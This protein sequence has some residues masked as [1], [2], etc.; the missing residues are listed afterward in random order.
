VVGRYAAEIP[1][2]WRVAGGGACAAGAQA[3]GV[4]RAS[5]EAVKRCTV[6][7]SRDVDF[8]VLDPAAHSWTAQGLLTVVCT[9]GVAYGVRL[10]GGSSGDAD[11][12]AMRRGQDLLPYG[13]YL[14]PGF[15]QPWGSASSKGGVGTGRA[16]LHPVYGRILAPSLP[17]AG[18]YVDEVI[19]TVTY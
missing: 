3:T 11:A 13:L 6:S 4:L 12:R 18:D 17:P 10:G 1:V 7:V 8:G 2:S 19:V 15:S 5:A 16:D 9:N 14:D